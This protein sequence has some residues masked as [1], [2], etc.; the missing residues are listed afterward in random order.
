MEYLIGMLR[1]WLPKVAPVAV[2]LGVAF[3]IRGCADAVQNLNMERTK[4]AGLVEANTTLRAALVNKDKELAAAKSSTT[5]RN[6]T[7][8]TRDTYDEQ[9]VL[10]EHEIA[11]RDVLI[12]SLMEQLQE[13]ETTPDV[14]PP[15]PCPEGGAGVRE[16]YRLGV[17]G[18]ATTGRAA[19]GGIDYTLA[20]LSPPFLPPLDVNIGAGVL[21][22]N[23]LTG[24]GIMGVKAVK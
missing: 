8:V 20:R 4:R 12:E 17:F 6:T 14:H 2:L 19:G 5:K 1:M 18:A 24:L 16:R 23:G 3:A 21:Y 13:L 11:E 10:R 22:G 7:K 9:G 15:S